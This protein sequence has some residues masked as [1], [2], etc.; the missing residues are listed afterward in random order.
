MSNEFKVGDLVVVKD[1]LGGN[2]ELLKVL[3]LYRSKWVTLSTCD[4]S[5]N[6]K[7]PIPQEGLR[8]ATAGEI[9][10]YWAGVVNAGQE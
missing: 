10:Q 3:Q 5:T 8:H 4:G 7:L 9:I 6:F 2:S 1:R